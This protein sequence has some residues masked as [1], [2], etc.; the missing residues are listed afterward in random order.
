MPQKNKF[1]KGDYV[2]F[3]TGHDGEVL[4]EGTVDRASYH[5]PGNIRYSVIMKND[6]KQST[7]ISEYHLFS[8]RE[9]ALSL[10]HT[11]LEKLVE[12]FKKRL[13]KVTELLEEGK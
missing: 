3:F 9:E 2:Y 11:R 5:G 7:L 6:S 1:K 8:S 13:D 12:Y 4:S 10:E